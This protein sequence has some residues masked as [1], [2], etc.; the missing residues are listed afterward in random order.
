MISMILALVFVSPVSLTNTQTA[1]ISKVEK[2]LLA[3]CC[4]LQSIAEHGSGIAVQMRNEVA[5]M[6]ADGQS[7]KEIVDHYRSIYG[8]R[9][10][11][12][13]DGSKAYVAVSPDSQ[14]AIIDLKTLSVTGTIE[15]GKG[16]DGMAWAVRK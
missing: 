3:P 16:P 14:I 5:E 15:T 10:L 4:Y 6:V 9:I 13:P 2:R 8:D 7:E 11:V 12:V 1:E